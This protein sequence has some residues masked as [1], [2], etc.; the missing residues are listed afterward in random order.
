MRATLGTGSDRGESALGVVTSLLVPSL[1]SG[2]ASAT[3]G[4]TILERRPDSGR[5]SPARANICFLGI[6]A[7]DPVPRSSPHARADWPK[8]FTAKTRRNHRVEGSNSRTTTT[9]RR[10]RRRR[11][12]RTRPPTFTD[13]ANHSSQRRLQ[14]R[15]QPRA[16]SVTSVSSVVRNDPLDSWTGPCRAGRRFFHHRGHGGHGGVRQPRLSQGRPADRCNHL[17]L[18]LRNSGV[19]RAVARGMAS[20]RF[21]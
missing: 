9:T 14:P 6:S 17:L 16:I 7:D 10:R 21:S 3:C 12:R 13:L 4:A 20:V 2:L 19:R 18:G 5:R 1:R 15:A 11:R 8:T